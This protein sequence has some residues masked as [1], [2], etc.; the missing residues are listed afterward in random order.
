MLRLLAALNSKRF[1][2]YLVDR[3]D[4]KIGNIFFYTELT[5]AYYRFIAWPPLR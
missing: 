4:I 2:L 5:V 1:R 3:F